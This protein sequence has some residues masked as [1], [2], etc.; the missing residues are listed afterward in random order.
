M[1]RGNLPTT[2]RGGKGGRVQAAAG[3][4]W[5][6]QRVQDQAPPGANCRQGRAA[7]KG[8]TE[9][10]LQG[11]CGQRGEQS[12][13]WVGGSQGR[14]W[15]WQAVQGRG[16]GGGGCWPQPAGNAEAWLCW[17]ATTRA[18]AFCKGCSRGA[19]GE[20]S[21]L[22]DGSHAAL[23]L[24]L[25]QLAG[26]ALRPAQGHRWRSALLR[27]R[28][29]RRQLLLRLRRLL[30]VL[31][32]QRL[33]GVVGV[34]HQASQAVPLL[35]HRGPFPGGRQAGRRWRLRGGSAGRVE[36]SAPLRGA[37]KGGAGGPGW[38]RPP[39]RARGAPGC[40]AARPRRTPRAPGRG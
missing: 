40:G 29:W 13:G 18:R 25:L 21:S 34:L 38:G 19:A 24:L 11:R 12:A 1:P 3:V 16:G 15:E 5:A 22:A 31:L 39:Q 23:L 9:R 2:T 14:G 17:L 7:T 27:R 37:C 26:R 10:R 4:V 30:H 20:L 36:P 28:R 8:T 33:F 6:G 35:H 32:R